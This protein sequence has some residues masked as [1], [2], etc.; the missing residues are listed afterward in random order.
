[1]KQ[2]TTTKTK[3]KVKTGTIVAIAIAVISVGG[4]VAGVYGKYLKNNPNLP[5]PTA[6]IDYPADGAKVQYGV[7]VTFKG[8]ATG[9]SGTGYVYEWFNSQGECGSGPVVC[10]GKT[11]TK[12][13]KPGNIVWTTLRVKDSA[14]Q[15]SMPVWVSVSP[16][17]DKIPTPTPT[18]TPKI[19]PTPIPTPKPSPTP[20]R[21]CSE[22]DGGD[23]PLVGGNTSFSP[24][25]GGQ[26]SPAYDHCSGN[27]IV[28]YYCK[29][30]KTLGTYTKD[31]GSILSGGAC[32]TNK[33]IGCY[34]TDGGNKPLIG[35]SVSFSPAIGG[36]VSPAYDHC[37]GNSIVEYY[38]KS[39][40]TIG[41]ETKDCKTVKTNG[42][43]SVNKCQ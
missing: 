18:T 6:Y 22:T 16:T 30:D 2:A 21:S 11:C 25:V 32:S 39:D 37:S 9:G 10:T 8:R 12:T 17:Y 42:V 13:F 24:A 38:C 36:Q 29:S 15:Y 20:V 33:C 14:G 5:R 19:T 7:P 23:K 26:V 28:E 3:T 40:K 1:M 43:C 27:S 41:V 31:C 4:I 35:G 34:D